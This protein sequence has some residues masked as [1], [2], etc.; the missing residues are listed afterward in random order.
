MSV[1]LRAAGIGE[2]AG[3]EHQVGALRQAQD[4]R[5]AACEHRGA[6]HHAIGKPTRCLDVQVADLADE[7][8][9]DLHIVGFTYFPPMTAVPYAAPATSKLNEKCWFSACRSR[10]KRC[11]ESLV[12]FAVW[13]WTYQR[14]STS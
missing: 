9:P 5:D 11:R 12:V 6:V 1:F 13:D 14:L 10:R 7:K 3:G 4:F 8:L 2:I